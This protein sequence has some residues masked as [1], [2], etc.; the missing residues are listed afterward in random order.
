MGWWGLKHLSHRLLPPT[1]GSASR[2]R[3]GVVDIQTSHSAVGCGPPKGKLNLLQHNVHAKNKQ[4][5]LMC[6]N[7]MMSWRTESFLLGNAFL[8]L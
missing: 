3:S 1:F 8:Y 5:Y 2:V 7:P 4:Q 6:V